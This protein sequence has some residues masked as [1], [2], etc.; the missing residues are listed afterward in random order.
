MTAPSP[1]LGASYD[2]AEPGVT[3][4]D[5]VPYA[6]GFEDGYYSAENGLAETRHV[7]LDGNDLPTRMARS[8]HLTIAET[9]F[10]HRSQSSGGHGVDG[11]AS[12]LPCRFYFG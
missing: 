10:W 9:G 8:P 11:A 5:G 2:L 7:F 12:T 3:F 4:R 1:H 6:A